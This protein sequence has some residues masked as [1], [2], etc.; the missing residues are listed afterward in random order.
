VARNEAGLRRQENCSGPRPKTVLALGA[1]EHRKKSLQVMLTRQS[2]GKHE[3]EKLTPK[4]QPCSV[5]CV[6]ENAVRG[7]IFRAMVS[8]GTR[9][10]VSKRPERVIR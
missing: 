9:C 3:G 6:L 8:V 2:L 10:R 1:R 7:I 5:F 4:S